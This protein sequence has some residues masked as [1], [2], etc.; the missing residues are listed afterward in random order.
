MGVYL[1]GKQ[2]QHFQSVNQ[3]N[4]QSIQP[5]NPL[6]HK[7]VYTNYSCT[8]FCLS[9]VWLVT[10]IDFSSVLRPQVNY[11]IGLDCSSDFT[12][13]RSYPLRKNGGRKTKEKQAARAV[14]T[15]KVNTVFGAVSSALRPIRVFIRLTLRRDSCWYHRDSGV[16]SAAFVSWMEEV[17][18]ALTEMGR[19]QCCFC[20]WKVCTM[21]ER[22]EVVVLW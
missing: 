8:Q 12:R 1:R 13:L 3:N 9:W 5:V 17:C 6:A 14:L 15:L 2:L 11:F 4:K 19:R 20:S 21:K 10:W 16:K 7:W 22:F 18:K